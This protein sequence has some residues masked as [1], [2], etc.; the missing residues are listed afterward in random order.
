MSWLGSALKQL[1]GQE[2]TDWVFIDYLPDPGLGLADAPIEPDKCYIEIFVESLRVKRARRFA[3]LFHGLVYSFVRLSREGVEDAE[4]A[5]ASKPSKLAA[6]DQSA[7]DRVITVSHRVVGAVP[8]RG[9]TLGLEVGLFSVKRGNLLSDVLDYVT[10]VSEVGGIG[11]VGQVKPFLPLITRGMDL[12]A[13]QVEDV[14]IEVALDTDVQLD[15]SRLCAIVAIPKASLDATRISLDPVDRK[16]LFNGEPLQ[17]AYCVF[18]I[19]RTNRKAD[20]GSIPEIKAAWEALRSATR[21]NDKAEAEAALSAFRRNAII[22]ADLI[23][24]DAKR[25]IR[26]AEERF[27]DAFPKGPVRAG[28]EGAGF[29]IGPLEEVDLYG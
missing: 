28:R 2:A 4:L 14:V 19:R 15:K 23:S 9:G 21:A 22:C 16:L 13:R 3:T 8:W 12:I 20:F 5:S 24:G 11:F 27:Q 7:V 10:R 6:L 29:D 1:I 17:E 26:K 25:L 18:S